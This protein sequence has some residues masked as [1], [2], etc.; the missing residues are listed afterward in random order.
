[1]IHRL[2]M[3]ITH[4]SGFFQGLSVGLV[5]EYEFRAFS[6]ITEVLGVKRHLGFLLQTTLAEG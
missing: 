5:R 3:T 4:S 6:S 1:M 2:S